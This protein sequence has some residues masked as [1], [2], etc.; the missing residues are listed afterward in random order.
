[1]RLKARPDLTYAG[2]DFKPGDTFDAL[3]QDG[4]T[5]INQDKAFP[6]NLEDPSTIT[7]EERV[8]GLLP[9]VPS[10]TISPTSEEL[11]AEGGEGSFGVS[12]TGP[13]QSGTWTVDKDGV[14]TWLTLVSP[15][16]PQTEDGT[17]TYTV[18]ANEGEARRANFYVNGKTFTVSQLAP[19]AKRS[20]SNR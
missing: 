8:E 3:E 9:D 12:I 19:E 11:A 10:V 13:G 16:T 14:A 17:V 5:F 7:L 6:F 4:L 20:R 2:K 15:T 18:D 1:M